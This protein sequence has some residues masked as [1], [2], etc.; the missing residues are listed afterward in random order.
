MQHNVKDFIVIAPAN[1]GKAAEW[2][3]ERLSLYLEAHFPLY[4]FRIEPFGPLS[5]DDEFTVVPIMNEMPEPGDERQ[6]H[7]GFAILHLDPMALMEIRGVLRAFDL[8][9]KVAN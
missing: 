6:D 9:G 4:R 8:A 2:A 5:S 7:D 3:A 1:Q